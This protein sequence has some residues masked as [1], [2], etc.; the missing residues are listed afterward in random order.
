MNVPRE[1][2]IAEIKSDFDILT[3]KS[4]RWETIHARG[5]GLVDKAQGLAVQREKDFALVE[6]V[7]RNAATNR[8]ALAKRRNE[9]VDRL[10]PAS[11]AVALPS[12]RVLHH[13]HKLCSVAY[14]IRVAD[15]ERVLR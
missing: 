14:L 3:E 8:I 7:E 11:L 4:E 12:E 1:I 10:V 6:R 13:A 5:H 15:G 2:A 9:S